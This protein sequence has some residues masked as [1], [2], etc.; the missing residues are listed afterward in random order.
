MRRNN[1][2]RNTRPERCGCEHLNHFNR[3]YDPNIH[4]EVKIRRLKHRYQRVEAGDQ[5][6]MYVGHICDDCAATCMKGWLVED[7]VHG[8]GDCT[9]EVDSHTS[10]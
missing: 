8:E 6:G 2:K 4:K 7:H 10:T 9:R 5:W 3:A 1:P